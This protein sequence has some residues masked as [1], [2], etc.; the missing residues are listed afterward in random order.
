MFEAPNLEKN[1]SCGCLVMKA[2]NYYKNII[3]WDYCCILNFS[4]LCQH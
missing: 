4:F 2:L 1:Y 3:M